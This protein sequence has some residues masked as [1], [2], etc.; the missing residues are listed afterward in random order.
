MLVAYRSTRDARKDLRR[1]RPSSVNVVRFGMLLIAATDDL[2]IVA[3][4]TCIDD[5]LQVA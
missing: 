3:V 4:A 1:L 2:K 5:R